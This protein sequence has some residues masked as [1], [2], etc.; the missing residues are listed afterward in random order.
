MLLIFCGLPGTG[1]S[2]LAKKLIS[3]FKA[4]HLNSDVIRKELFKERTY[5]EEEKEQVYLK[6]FELTEQ[7]LKKETNVILDATFFKDF[8]RKKVVVLAKKLKVPFYFIECTL[9]S[10]IVKE[11]IL[12]RKNS[13]S[14]ADFKVYQKLKRDFEPIRQVHLSLD[15]SQN[16][17][18]Q[19]EKIQEF[20]SKTKKQKLI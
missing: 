7:E 16:F 2:S 9:P 4:V 3:K 1:K 11:R 8:Y 18:E 17:K 10:D 6:L 14:E 5:S 12:S 13:V 19:F 15:M 20:I